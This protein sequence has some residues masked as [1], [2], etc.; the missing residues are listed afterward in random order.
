MTDRLGSLRFV[1]VLRFLVGALLVLGLAG[2]APGHDRTGEADC[3]PGEEAEA[4]VRL[5]GHDSLR[6]PHGERSGSISTRQR[7]DRI[8]IHIRV[9]GLEPGATYE[10]VAS[11][12]TTT[13]D[14]EGNEVQETTSASLGTITTRDAEPPDPRCFKAHLRA[15]EPE[16]PGNGGDPGGGGAHHRTRTRTP[17]ALAVLTLDE[18]RTTLSSI[19]WVRGLEGSV[20]GVTL[21]L[22]DESIALE[23]GENNRG[24]IEVTEDQVAAL[25][26]GGA[27]VSLTTDADESLSGEVEPCFPFLQRLAERLAGSGALRLDTERGDEIPFVENDARDLEGTIVDVVDSEGNVVLSGDID[28]LTDL[29]ELFRRRS[30][31]PWHFGRRSECDDPAAEEGD[32]G[33]EARALVQAPFDENDAIDSMDDASFFGIS[34]VHDASFR[35]GDSNDDGRFDIADP[36]HLLLHMFA[37]GRRPYCADAADAD[38]NGAVNISD[39]LVMLGELFQRRPPAGVARF[40]RTPDPLFCGAEG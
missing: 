13:T 39:V 1:C 27:S 28:E 32:D 35:R 15:D 7:G 19:V 40:D 8:A 26:A 25:V 14:G 3:E 23:L 11:Q 9:R 21:D 4:P 10:V 33:D 22:G 6:L 2:L 16:D 37:G 12:T 17:R 30:R 34:G 5:I 36:V 38:D 29:S 18:E 24:S 31:W 20:T